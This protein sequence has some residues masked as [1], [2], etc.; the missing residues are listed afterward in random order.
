MVTSDRARCT[1]SSMLSELLHVAAT[2]LA[3]AST[4]VIQTIQGERN[5]H[6]VSTEVISI[7]ILS[8]YCMYV[9]VQYIRTYICL[10]DMHLQMSCL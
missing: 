2:N 3:Q 7:F 8:S 1:I 4:K 9:Y 5:V 6:L 10:C